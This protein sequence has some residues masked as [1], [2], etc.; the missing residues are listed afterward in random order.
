[1]NDPI[2]KEALEQALSDIRKDIAYLHRD[3]ANTSAHKVKWYL[4][5]MW[6]GTTLLLYNVFHWEVGNSILVATLLVLGFFVIDGVS[7]Q[8]NAQKSL[9]EPI[10]KLF[11]TR[12]TLGKK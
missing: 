7:L 6:L 12:V 2:D 8:V 9:K 5:L 10:D 3:L 11:D 1:M 4:I